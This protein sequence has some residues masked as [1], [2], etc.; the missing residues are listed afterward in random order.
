MPTQQT[1]RTH[2]LQQ[3]HSSLN[4]IAITNSS[5]KALPFPSCSSFLPALVATITFE[6][7]YDWFLFHF[8]NPQ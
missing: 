7:S 4:R 2:L 3:P 5:A 1:P 8:S 6:P